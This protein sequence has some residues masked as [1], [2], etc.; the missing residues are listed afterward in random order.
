MKIPH[1]KRD[2]FFPLMFLTAIGLCV[3]CFMAHLSGTSTFLSKGLS[4]VT[5]PLRIAAKGAYNVCDSI[6]SYFSDIDALLKENEALKKQNK[7][8]SNKIKEISSLEKENEWLYKSL[9]LKNERTDFKLTNANIISK[10]TSGYSEFFTIDKGSFHGIKENMPIITNDG[11][12]LGITYSVEGSST[13]CK[14]ILSYDISLGIYNA[15]TGET[16]LLSGS[17]D[18]F[19]KNMC[20]ISDISDDTTMQSGDSIL[21]SGLGDIYPRGLVVGKVDSFTPKT[22]SHTRNALITLESLLSN[23]ESIM[24]ITEFERIYE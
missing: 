1:R 13:R 10:S 3:L 11:A 9:D 8:L 24:I 5:T 17:F 19:K 21:T 15:A 4:F 7:D 12:L 16:G 22:A 14:S 18:A 20:A 6:S 2:L 23:N